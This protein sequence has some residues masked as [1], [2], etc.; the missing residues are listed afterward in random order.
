MRN[1]SEELPEVAKIWTDIIESTDTISNQ[2]LE[3]IDAWLTFA[4]VDQLVDLLRAIYRQ[5]QRSPRQTAAAAELD[6][7]VAF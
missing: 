2:Q 7:T 6:E 4:T 5:R 3:Q 1:E